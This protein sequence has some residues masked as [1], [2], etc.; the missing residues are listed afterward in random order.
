MSRGHDRRRIPPWAGFV[1]AGA[2]VLGVSFLLPDGVPGPG[3]YM[4]AGGLSAAAM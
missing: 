2:T 1:A 3:L 4:A